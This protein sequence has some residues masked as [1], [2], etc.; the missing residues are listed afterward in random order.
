MKTGKKSATHKYSEACVDLLKK[1]Q[2]GKP[3]EQQLKT[4]VKQAAT[5]P[6]AAKGKKP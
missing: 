3:Y 2:A 4:G 1:G 5:E 6:T